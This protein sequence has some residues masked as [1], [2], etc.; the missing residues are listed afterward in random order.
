MREATIFDCGSSMRSRREG[1]EY[2]LSTDLFHLPTGGGEGGHPIQPSICSSTDI[3]T[4]WH[5]SITFE[6]G[7]HED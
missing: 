5:M 2:R 4:R 6:R 1:E 7:Y 3:L